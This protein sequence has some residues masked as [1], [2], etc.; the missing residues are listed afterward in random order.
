M[1]GFNLYQESQIVVRT[2][3]LE[4]Y[5]SAAARGVALYDQFNPTLLVRLLICKMR[6]N[7]DNIHLVGVVLGM[8]NIGVISERCAWH[9]V[10]DSR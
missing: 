8:K 2:R 3:K 1:E 7:S 5:T 9:I 4:L 6:L 10:L